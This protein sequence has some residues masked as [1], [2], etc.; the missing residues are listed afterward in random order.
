MELVFSLPEFY[1]NISMLTD[2]T[3]GCHVFCIELFCL[4][5]LRIISKF[6]FYKLSGISIFMIS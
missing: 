6:S 1:Q 3:E 2:L 4:V 5:L